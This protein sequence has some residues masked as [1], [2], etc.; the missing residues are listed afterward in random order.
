V[1]VVR[2]DASEKKLKEKKTF[3]GTTATA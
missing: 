2:L 1:I 3:G